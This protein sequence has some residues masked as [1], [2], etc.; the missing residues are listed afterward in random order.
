MQLQDYLEFINPD[1]IHLKG[2]RIGIEDV[3]KIVLRWML[4]YCDYGNSDNSI[5]KSL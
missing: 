5:I 1:E 2:H 4:V 3:I